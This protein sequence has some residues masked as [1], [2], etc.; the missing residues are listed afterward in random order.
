MSWRLRRDSLVL[1]AGA[2]SAGALVFAAF[3]LVR[4]PRQAGEAA[5]ARA[6]GDVAD[7]VVAEWERLLRTEAPPF[8]PAGELHDWDPATAIG[9]V[10]SGFESPA[11]SGTAI[12]ALLGE[13]RRLDLAGDRAGALDFA[14]QAASASTEGG[15][16]AHSRLLAI[17]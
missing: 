3:G 12:A 14:L 11:P 13:A 5:L 16:Q 7:A 8:D 9:G 2:L 17:Q 1:L 15:S 6:G 10:A 4:A